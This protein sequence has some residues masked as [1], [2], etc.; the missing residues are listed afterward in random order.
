MKE[1]VWSFFPVPTKKNKAIRLRTPDPLSF[2]KQK[3]MNQMCDYDAKCEQAFH[4]GHVH[5]QRGTYAT[6]GCTASATAL[7]QCARKQQP[8]M[9]NSMNNVGGRQTLYQTAQE[10][11]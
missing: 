10:K 6:G 7:V 2:Q 3:K 1:F 8:A 5:Q 9:A 11:L 4:S